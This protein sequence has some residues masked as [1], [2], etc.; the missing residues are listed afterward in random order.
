MY[1]RE[2]RIVSFSSFAARMTEG[3]RGIGLFLALLL[4][5]AFLI[6]AARTACAQAG[7][8]HIL[9]GDVKVDESKNGEMKPLTLDIILYYTDGRVFSRQK[10]ANNGR[11]RFFGLKPNEYELAVELD[12]REI[13]RVRVNL[14]TVGAAADHRQDIELEWK[15]NDT[16]SAHSRKQTVSA[17][18]FYSRSPSNKSNFEKAQAAID[19]KKYEEGILLLRQMVDSDAK[20]FQAWSE[21]GTAYLLLDKKSE[22]EKAYTRAVEEKPTFFLALLNLGRVRSA[23][24]KHEEAIEPL[25]RAVELQATSAEANFLLG[26]AYLQTKKGSKAVGYLEEAARLGRSDAHLRLAALYNAVGLKDRAAAEYE[27]FLSKEP[28]YADKSRL[29]AYIKANKK[30]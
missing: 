16:G 17:E 10:V 26:E 4:I 19:K 3:R 13:G 27:Q 1:Q 7:S 20:D 15:T 25:S 24:K 29:E 21:L 22:A 28:S 2:M 11:Y 18:D 12:N 23:Q 5:G 8:G 6:T 9:F 14:G 30:Q